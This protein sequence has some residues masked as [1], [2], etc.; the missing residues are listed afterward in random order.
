MLGQDAGICQGS[1]SPFI[2]HHMQSPNNNPD[3]R[4]KGA[5]F[6]SPL[7]LGSTPNPPPSSAAAF[8]VPGDWKGL[9]RRVLGHS[10]RKC[11]SQQSGKGALTLFY[12]L[13]G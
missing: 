4:L 2:L 13:S 10:A 3:I 12:N 9:F 1:A 11:L 7:G 6:Q 8:H 5:G